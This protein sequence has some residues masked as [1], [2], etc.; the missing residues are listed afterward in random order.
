MR[1]MMRW[2]LVAT[3]LAFTG[4]STP[5]STPT[6][7]TPI[8][9]EEGASADDEASKALARKLTHRTDQ[10]VP[11]DRCFARCAQAE[12]TCDSGPQSAHSCES[13]TTPSGKRCDDVADPAARNNCHSRVQTCTTRG[14]ADFCQSRKRSCLDAC[15]AR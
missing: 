8:T 2:T 14:S 13:S 11:T 7:S 3:C 15:N 6:T 5:Q 12:K 10:I 9:S 4:W 1:A